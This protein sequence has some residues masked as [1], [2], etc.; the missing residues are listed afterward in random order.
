PPGDLPGA[1]G[2]DFAAAADDERHDR[3]LG[4]EREHEA[5]LL[6]RQEVLTRRGARAFGEDHHRDALEHLVLGSA[7]ARDRLLAIAAIDDDVTRMAERPSE[8]RDPRELLLR[9]PAELEL[10]ERVDHREDVGLTAVIGHEDVGRKRIE[11]SE[12][13]DAYADPEEREVEPRPLPAQVIGSPLVEGGGGNRKHRH[14]SRVE[15]YAGQ[16][17]DRGNNQ[18][19]LPCLT[20]A[21]HSANVFACRRDNTGAGGPK[22]TRCTARRQSTV[23]R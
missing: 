12:P 2:K 23:T 22:S 7:Q 17:Q 10:F 16:L 9:H 4:L 14:H 5:A 20:A 1:G 3:E 6:E 19:W 15:R 11:R 21:P 13:A 18:R 8:Q